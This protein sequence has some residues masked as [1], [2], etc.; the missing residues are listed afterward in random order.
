MSVLLG[1][2]I[3]IS[4]T[5]WQALLEHNFPD[6]LGEET[7]NQGI[8]V[9]SMPEKLI[10]EGKT[11]GGTYINPITKEVTYEYVDIASLPPSPEQEITTF[12][13]DVSNIQQ[14]I[15]EISMLLAPTP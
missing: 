12:K 7:L 10:P 15:A 9:E 11:L 13:T 5:K 2:F 3:K 6:Q 1:N 14:S 8:L 4:D